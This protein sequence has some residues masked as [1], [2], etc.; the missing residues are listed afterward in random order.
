[1]WLLGHVASSMVQYIAQWRK[2]VYG[3]LWMRI[4]I[5]ITICEAD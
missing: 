3:G 4:T 5:T 2:Y 1:M